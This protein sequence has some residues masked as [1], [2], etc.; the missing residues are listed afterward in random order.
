MPSVMTSDVRDI[1]QII[2]SRGMMYSIRRG[3]EFLWL[4]TGLA[5]GLYWYI[6]PHYYRRKYNSELSVYEIP[7]D[8][9]TLRWVNPKSITRFSGREG[10]YSD[11]VYSIGKIKS[12]DWDQKQSYEDSELRHVGSI[13]NNLI[14]KGFKKR[15]EEG[16]E[17]EDTKFI[18]EVLKRVREGNACWHNCK[19]EKEVFER[20]SFIDSLYQR[21][22]IEGYKTQSEL[23][24]TRDTTLETAGFFNE[25]INEIVVD[26][27][28][29]GEPLL[30]DARHRLILSRILNIDRIP[31]QIICRHTQWMERMET[32][33]RNG[34]GIN[35]P[36]FRAI[37]NNP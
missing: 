1:K 12:G 32:A 9:F 36:D 14:Y 29:D 8:P 16:A 28:R 21:L 17:W 4:K 22:K 10:S 7:I 13:E 30:V 23:R 35:H 31:V 6:A 19:T 11:L 3:T 34:N 26:I 27:A 37:E 33:Y 20:C 5:T 24:K 2:S 18:Q 15:F 25:H